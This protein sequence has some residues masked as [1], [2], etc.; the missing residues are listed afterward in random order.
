MCCKSRKEIRINDK[1]S[2]ESLHQ[3]RV[4]SAE[5]MIQMRLLDRQTEKP[6]N[7]QT[8]ITTHTRTIKSSLLADFNI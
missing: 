2:A 3:A 4:S 7:R 6:Y 1:L 5:K 8:Q